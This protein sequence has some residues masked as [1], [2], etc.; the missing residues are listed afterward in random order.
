[1]TQEII[2][3]IGGFIFV[4][5]LIV[6][7]YIIDEVRGWWRS[8]REMDRLEKEIDAENADTER[9][10]QFKALLDSATAPRAES[11]SQQSSTPTPP[12]R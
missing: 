1:M 3:L 9:R 6:F 5:A 2:I 7:W 10:A 12:A 11:P 8:V 4:C